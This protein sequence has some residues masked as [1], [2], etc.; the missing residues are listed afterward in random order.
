MNKVG[1]GAL[2]LSFVSWTGTA[3][4]HCAP[5]DFLLRLVA[6]ANFLRLSLTK[7]AN[8]AVGEDGVAGNPGS[9]LS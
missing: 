5:P 9:L 4:P 8:V 3:D 1:S 7:A 2:L 6:S